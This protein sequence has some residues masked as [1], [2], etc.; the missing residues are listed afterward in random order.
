MLVRTTL[1]V[2]DYLRQFDEPAGYLDFARFG[3]VSAGVLQVLTR[4]AGRMHSGHGWD[5]L[6]EL[7]A[8]TLDA[9]RSAADLLGARPEEIAFVGSTSHGLFAAAHALAGAAPA[10]GA[11]Q[12]PGAGPGAD[13]ASGSRPA[14]GG[15]GAS[16]AGAAPG[17]VLVGRRDFPG[18]VYP[19]LRAADHGGLAV[20][21]IDGPVT[22]DAVRAHLD[23]TVR[24]VSVCAVDAAT[25][26]RAPLAEIREVVGPDRVLVVDAVQALGAVDLDAGPADVLACGGQKWLRAGWGAALLLVRDRVA[27]R[28]RPGLSGWSGVVDPIDAPHHPRPPR[29][30]AVAH[31][32]TN[33]DG[34]AVAALGAGLDLV[35]SVGPAR[36]A[37]LVAEALDGLLDAALSAGAEVAR[38]VGGS[39]I[40]RLRL[41]GADP[42]AVHRTLTDSG[43]ATTLRGGWI[44]LSPH[45]ST[46]PEA[47][48][49]LAG[50][51]RSVPVT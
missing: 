51:L 25:G 36:L 15:G 11:G 18:A 39:G 50:A 5:T 48:A 22:A 3:P 20:R 37:A 27:D 34:P 43:L 32:L 42:R 10:P 4:A 44:R 28:L 9:A 31:T 24:A 8:A 49:R 29:P 47:A 1:P 35:R 45:A 40:G 16:G 2:T 41:P 6:A 23:G 46:G 7:D 17:T 12:G 14:A 30:G 19:W 33:P 38:P 26:F 21:P 13:R